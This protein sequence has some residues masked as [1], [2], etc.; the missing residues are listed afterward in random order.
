M[1]GIDKNELNDIKKMIRDSKLKSLKNEKNREKSPVPS[2]AKNDKKMEENTATA[3]FYEISENQKDLLKEFIRKPG[4]PKKSIED[5][6]KKETVYFKSETLKYLK[7]FRPELKVSKKINYIIEDYQRLSEWQKRVV[8]RF[9][10]Y[11]K[12]ID[13]ITRDLDQSMI[14][15]SKTTNKFSEQI[16]AIA[17]EVR[18]YMNILDISM[19]D[20]EKY[21]SSDV[22]RNLTFVLGYTR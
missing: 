4:R 14:F 13:L 10:S 9:E 15:D 11:S 7:R 20:I 17:K 16:F 19:K 21:L 1:L 12:K 5:K 18:V 2:T 3:I 22:L 8:S 6:S